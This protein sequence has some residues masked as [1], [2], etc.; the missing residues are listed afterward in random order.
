V[1][2]VAVRLVD[3]VAHVLD[4]QDLVKGQLVDGL[5]ELDI[6]HLQHALA[7]WVCMCVCGVG[8]WVGG[9]VQK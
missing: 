6:K 3:G 1:W 5:L 9:R 8:G 2:L 7:A 4:G